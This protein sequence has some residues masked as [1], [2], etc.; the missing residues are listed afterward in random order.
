MVFT[1]PLT[2]PQEPLVG[3][4]HGVRWPRYVNAKKRLHPIDQEMTIRG[5]AAVA[6]VLF[7]QLTLSLSLT[8]CP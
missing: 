4:N 8:T 2:T 5:G 3:H 7:I 1:G 6:D